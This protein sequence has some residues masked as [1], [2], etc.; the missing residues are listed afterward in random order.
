MNEKELKEIAEQIRVIKD[1]PTLTMEGR[2][3]LKR[4]ANELDPPR[5]KP[6]FVWFKP[7]HD[8]HGNWRPGIMRLNGIIQGYKTSY[9]PEMVHAWERASTHGPDEVVV[10]IPPV[11]EWP[12][13]AGQILAMYCTVTSARIAPLTQIITRAEV[14]EAEHG[15]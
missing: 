3:A 9:P 7:V 15:E 1:A 10:K 6:V 13:Q 4:I 8:P 5:P 12:E 2:D 14:M 11:S